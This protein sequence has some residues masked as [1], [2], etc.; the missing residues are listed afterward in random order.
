MSCVTR[1]VMCTKAC[2]VYQ[3]MWCVSRHVGC[4]VV[5]TEACKVCSGLVVYTE[6]TKVNNSTPLY[7]F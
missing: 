7:M 5:C 2:G 6:H 4:A 3:G 1:Y